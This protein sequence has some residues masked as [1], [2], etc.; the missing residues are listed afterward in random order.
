ML[1]NAHLHRDSSISLAFSVSFSETR[2]SRVS[3]PRSRARRCAR[4]LEPFSLGTRHQLYPRKQ[5]YFEFHLS[6]IYLQDYIVLSK[7]RIAEERVYR[8]RDIEPRWRGTNG[9]RENAFSLE[10]NDNSR[11][12]FCFPWRPRFL[13][14]PPPVRGLPVNIKRSVIQPSWSFRSRRDVLTHGQLAPRKLPY[15]WERGSR[16]VRDIFLAAPYAYDLSRRE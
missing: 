5:R 3:L 4:I 14:P 6:V 11:K 10:N 12:T 15:A 1:S 7:R 13:E 2:A 16:S 8:Y 9:A